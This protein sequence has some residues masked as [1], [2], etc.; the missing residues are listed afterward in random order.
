M[1]FFT[2]TDLLSKSSVNHTSSSRHLY[3]FY[4]MFSER[5]LNHE[6]IISCC[7]TST[8]VFPHYQNI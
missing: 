2:L 1:F 4:C 7:W 8:E 3:D 6:Q 5:F